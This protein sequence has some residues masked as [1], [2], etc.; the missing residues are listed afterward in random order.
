MVR[1]PIYY[2]LERHNYYYFENLPKV[3]EES[4]DNLQASR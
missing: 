3:T 2:E 1:R 4:D